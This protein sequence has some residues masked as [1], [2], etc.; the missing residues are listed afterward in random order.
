MKNLVLV[1]SVLLFLGINP[2][3]VRALAITGASIQPHLQAVPSSGGFAQFSFTL[4]EAPGLPDS[5]NYSGQVLIGGGLET[6]TV[7]ITLGPFAPGAS[8]ITATNLGPN[9]RPEG[10]IDFIF[11]PGVTGGFQTLARQGSP[12]LGVA[13]FPTLDLAGNGEVS[14]GSFR[15]SS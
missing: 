2:I 1:G 12:T 15:P 6:F 10:E 14:W 13:N 5:L 3:S 8:I 7:T 4:A 11:G 9:G